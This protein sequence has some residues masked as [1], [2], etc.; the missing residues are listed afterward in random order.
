MKSD[1]TVIIDV[2]TESFIL[3]LSFVAETAAEVL[4][5]ATAQRFALRTVE[6]AILQARL[7]IIERQ[8]QAEAEQ[9]RTLLAPVDTQI[10]S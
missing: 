9:A 3:Q 8:D 1:L 7:A 10:V 5:P 4:P 2:T 6:K